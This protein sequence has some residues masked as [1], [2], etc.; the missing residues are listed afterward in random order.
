MENDDQGKGATAMRSRRV[1]SSLGGGFIDVPDLDSPQDPPKD[2]SPGEVSD[3]LTF[4]SRFGP[5]HDDPKPGADG[6]NTDNKDKKATPANKDVA[7][8]PARVG[9]ANRPPKDRAAEAKTGVTAVP[10]EELDRSV[11]RKIGVLADPAPKPEQQAGTGQGSTDKKNQFMNNFKTNSPEAPLSGP[12]LGQGEPVDLF[13]ALEAA[14][15]P[16]L[17]KGNSIGRVAQPDS[18][19]PEGDAPEAPKHFTI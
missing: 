11:R 2:R 12:K 3:R 13:G 5:S 16:T 14:T 6:K 17:K 15:N 1:T 10:K 7:D 18:D 19:G 8:T 9:E 4:R